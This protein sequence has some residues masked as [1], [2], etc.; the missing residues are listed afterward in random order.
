MPAPAND[1]FASAQALSTTLPGSLPGL[2]TF[3]ATMEGS[4][5]KH[6]AGGSDI[7]QSIWFTFTPSVSGWYQF[8]VPLDS[9]VYHG[10]HDDTDGEINLILF[11]GGTV[12]D[13]LAEATVANRIA[14][15]NRGTDTTLTNTGW[16]NEH[17][18]TVFGDLVSGTTYYI[19]ICSSFGTVAN[20]STCD[21]DFEWDVIPLATNSDFANRETISG[22]SGSEVNIHLGPASWQSPDEPPT[23][24]WLRGF[25]TGHATLWYEWTCPAS[26]WYQF[27]FEPETASREFGGVAGAWVGDIAIY[28]GSALNALTPIVK[29]EVGSKSLIDV[30]SGQ[31]KIKFNA[32]NGTVYKIQLAVRA[33]NGIIGGDLGQL[34]W[35]TASAPTGDTGAAAINGGFNTT[36]VDNLGNTDNDTPSDAVSRLNTAFGDDEF[37]YNDGAVGRSKWYKQTITETGTLRI[38]AANFDET[39]Y[40]TYMEYGLLVYKGA[41]FGTIA[42]VTAQAGLDAVMIGYEGGNF[43]GAAHMTNNN[44]YMDLPVTAGDVVWLCW[45]TLYDEDVNNEA[46]QTAFATDA[47]QGELNLKFGTSGTPEVPPEN[48][49]LVGL[50]QNHDFFFGYSEW[51][52]GYN[53]STAGQRDG[54]THLATTEVGELAHGGYGPTR[55]VWYRLAVPETGQYKIWVES[56]VDCV[57]SV[58]EMPFPYTTIGSSLGEDD[59]S[60]TGTNPELTLN[61]I[62]SVCAVCVDSKT[63]G[64]FTVKFQKVP[65]G[66]PPAN[67]DIADA[68]EITSI[69]FSHAGTTHD[70]SAEPFERE[71]E[72]FGT[73][74][75]ATVW[76]KYVAPADG[77]FEVWCENVS[78]TN[79]AYV[80]VDL[81]RGDDP[82]TLERWPE[83]PPDY[84]RGAYSAD[85]Y[86]D[87]GENFENRLIMPVFSGETYYIR[88]QTEDNESEDFTVYMEEGSVYIKITPSAIEEMHGTLLD[89]AVVYVKLVGSAI[90]AD[91]IDAATVFIDLQ[92]SGTELKAFEYTDSAT[93]YINLQFMGGECF[94]A[95]TGLMMDAEA[96][97]RWIAGADCRWF[98]IDAIQRWEV[99]DVQSEG[100]HC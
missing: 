22:S 70:S 25:M 79:E 78:L 77:M 74:P 64:F 17:D 18:A 57:L 19:K 72:F 7:E 43:G 54:Y 35:A 68:I 39:T 13:T 31:T 81:W 16:A 51:W 63:E 8:R 6:Y 75:I 49:D 76:Y 45:V 2:T 66:T 53:D 83:P 85:P 41:T 21:F 95:H 99:V 20:R 86:V 47:P 44:E 40:S 89:D 32:T 62:N 34:R 80:Y 50:P 55:S 24:Y 98:V 27:E 96:D 1:N 9:L 61:L 100:V 38:E 11:K 92:A 48:D 97:P 4:E 15:P 91:K 12:V 52:S 33:D 90:F 14:N 60:G 28:T 42:A 56:D 36:L 93:V 23:S 46:T 88:V 29:N 5:P 73:G 94:S 71:A 37:Y 58:Y 69:P 87:P 84:P 10:T 82:N 26:G 3:D 67:D 30:G 59:D 65:T